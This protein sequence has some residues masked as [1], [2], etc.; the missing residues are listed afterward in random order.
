MVIGPRRFRVGGWT[1]PSEK[2]DIVNLDH[3][4]QGKNIKKNWNH[5]PDLYPYTPLL[6][7]RAWFLWRWNS[8]LHLL[9]FSE[10]PHIYRL[11]Q[12]IWAVQEIGVSN[13]QHF[14]TWKQL[15]IWFW[16]GKS[17]SSCV[18][19]LLPFFR[20]QPNPQ[21]PKNKNHDGSPRD[22]RI[23]SPKLSGKSQGTNFA[24]SKPR[25]D[26][27]K[28]LRS[29]NEAGCCHGKSWASSTA[30]PE[31]NNSWPL[32]TGRAPKR[33]PSIFMC[34]VLL[35]GKVYHYNLWAYK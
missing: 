32:K 27:V 30:L 28:D 4:H 18:C 6:V 13:H 8:S 14:L 9:P 7:W 23:D 25:Q 1:N 21:T 34:S 33:K 29:E 31:T 15:Y 10:S 22:S 20:E 35:L 5:Q 17:S 2:Y 26:D 3:F 19:Q 16:Y 12:L 24:I 11:Y